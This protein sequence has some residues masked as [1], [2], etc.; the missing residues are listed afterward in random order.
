MLADWV[1]ADPDLPDC[2]LIGC[3]SVTAW[4]LSWWWGNYSR[5]NTLPVIFADFGMGHVDRAWCSAHGQVIDIPGKFRCNWFKKPIAIMNCRNPRILWVDTDCEIRGD[6]RPALEYA[7]SPQGFSGAIDPYTLHQQRPT[8]NTGVLAVAQ[9]SEFVSQWATKC[10]LNCNDF[11]GDQE[12]LA[13][14]IDENN[15]Q[16]NILPSTYN[17]LRLAGV[18]DGSKAV[19]MHWTGNLGKNHIHRVISPQPVNPSNRPVS[20]PNPRAILVPPKIIPKVTKPKNLISL[21]SLK[22][23]GIRRPL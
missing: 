8:I 21:L 20:K 4:M 10:V 3:D 22:R 15:S 9:G 1:Q 14:L 18:D 7:S 6:L 13:T 5:H 11:R 23:Q 12:V 17:W 2:V 19:I 16:V